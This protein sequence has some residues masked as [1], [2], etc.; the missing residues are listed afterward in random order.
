LA[1]LETDAP[2]ADKVLEDYRV[3]NKGVE[4][5]L[6]G[7]KFATVPWEKAK[8]EIVQSPPH[9]RGT[10]LAS[11]NAAG[12]LESISDAKFEVNIPDA[13]MPPDRRAG[14][15]RFHAH[16]A[17]ENVSIHEAL[18]GHYLQMLHQREAASRVRKLVWVSTTG[19]GWAHY[20]EQAVMDT[21]YAMPDPTRAKAFYLRSALQRAARVVVDVA[22]NDGSMTVE[23]AAKFLEDNALLA[24]GTAQIEA[25]R[26][27]VWPVGMFAY[28]Y[29][30]LAIQKLRDK[31]RAREKDSFD[32]VRFHDRFLAIGAIPIRYIGP[33]AFGID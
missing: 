24:P 28:T 26:A 19:E 21:G 7:H 22:E 32:L 23:Q 18:P 31:V 10:S 29:G 13:R 8:L 16:G 9:M 14:L 11:M 17:E 6:R 4:E 1:R 25:R 27:I 33:A 15:L 30:K 20:C 2:K 12:P 3:A 5:W